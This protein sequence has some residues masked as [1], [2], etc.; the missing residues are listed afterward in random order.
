[1]R[2][3]DAEIKLRGWPVIALAQEYTDALRYNAIDQADQCVRLG[4]GVRPK[5]RCPLRACVADI[6][7]ITIAARTALVFDPAE[8]ADKAVLERLRADPVIE[9]I[10][11]SD[12]QLDEVRKLLP[13]PDP[14]LV[15]EPCRWA[16]YPWRRTV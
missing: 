13:P 14:E 6:K 8:P 7:E 3:R 5:S 1:M 12:S 10:D 11:H 15:A 16:Y 9:F 4:L 2:R